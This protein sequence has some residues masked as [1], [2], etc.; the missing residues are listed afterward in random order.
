VAQF[1][2]GL[3][4]AIASIVWLAFH[5]PDVQG[6]SAWYPSVTHIPAMLR[7]G[8]DRAGLA[9]HLDTAFVLDK[10]PV[11]EGFKRYVELNDRIRQGFIGNYPVA[12]KT[13]RRF[14]SGQFKD[15][16][17][18][19]DRLLSIT[20]GHGTLPVDLITRWCAEQAVKTY[21]K[22]GVLLKGLQ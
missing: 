14:E 21:A 6:F 9:W 12:R 4:D 17:A 1:R 5:N 15:Q 3:P 10:T 20:D 13:W 11:P 7:A 8:N 18:F 19:E 22:A 2:S 16:R